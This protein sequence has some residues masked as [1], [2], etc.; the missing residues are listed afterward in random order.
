MVALRD[1]RR[2]IVGQPLHLA[3]HCAIADGVRYGVYCLSAPWRAVGW[4]VSYLV[5]RLCGLLLRVAAVVGYLGHVKTKNQ[6]TK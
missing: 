3:G 2:I 5:G 4:V 6:L 1:V